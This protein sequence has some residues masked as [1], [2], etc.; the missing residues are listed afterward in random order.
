M[1]QLISKAAQVKHA[2]NSTSIC[3]KGSWFE[4]WLEY[5][6]APISRFMTCE[7]CGNT[8]PSSKMV[9][10]HVIDINTN[11]TYIYPTCKK[12]NDTY[13]ESKA[14]EKVFNVKRIYLCP[15]P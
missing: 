13:K 10:S 11:I 6:N 9:G 2:K 8:C 4:Y 12:C 7:C 14:D 1:S 5:T 15:L 3:P